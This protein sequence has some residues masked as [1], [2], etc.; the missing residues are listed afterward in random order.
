MRIR[1]V[2]VRRALPTALMNGCFLLRRV[3]PSHVFGKFKTIAAVVLLI[4]SFCCCAL[5]FGSGLLVPGRGFHMARSCY[6]VDVSM[7]VVSSFGG[8][9]RCPLLRS[10]S[11]IQFMHWFVAILVAL[12][13]CDTH[14]R[15]MSG[16][17]VGD[18]RSR[19][20]DG[21]G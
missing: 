15:V 10:S 5:C 2:L 18:W 8:T 17:S 6:R 21:V 7:D 16:P 4:V 14:V 11:S 12:A 9:Q 1:R 13:A 3:D 20:V 19:N